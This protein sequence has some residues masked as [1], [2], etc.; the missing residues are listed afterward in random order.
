MDNHNKETIIQMSKDLGVSPDLVS[1]RMKAIIKTPKVY[2]TPLSL[3]K[4]M[5]GLINLIE[6][7]KTGW[8]VDIAKQKLIKLQNMY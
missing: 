2:D 7:Y 4:E 8:A 3:D 1:S 5:N 6:T